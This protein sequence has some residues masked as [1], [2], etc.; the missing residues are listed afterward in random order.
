MN[1]GFW[2]G[3]RKTDPHCLSTIFLMGFKFLDFVFSFEFF[4]VEL[5]IFI[6]FRL[7][8]V[9]STSGTRVRNQECVREIQLQN[10]FEKHE[11][12]EIT[13]FQ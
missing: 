6:L 1:N 4:F 9:D 2:H 11:I 10:N 8:P 3:F 7:E 12:K 5:S 13:M